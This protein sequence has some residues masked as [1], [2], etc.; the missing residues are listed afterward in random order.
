M[1]K[2]LQI[3][4]DR[5]SWIAEGDG[6]TVLLLHGFGEDGSIWEQQLHCLKNH[7]KVLVPDLRGS[8]HS[9]NC[10]AS[11]SIEQMAQDLALI[12]DAENI[13]NCSILG[14]SMGGYIAL[15]FAERFPDRLQAL[16]LIHSTAFGDSPEKKQVRSK[17]IEF[18]QNNGSAT[19]FKT[20][21]PNLFHPDFQLQHPEVIERLL[22]QSSSF[23]DEVVIG[24]YK[25]MIHRPDR[26][27][28]LRNSK[29]PILIFIG[30][31]DKAVAP[32][33]ALLQASLPAIC[34][35]QLIEG[36][37]HMGMWEATEELNH[38]LLEFLR[39]AIE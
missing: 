12:L 5:F 14:H 20:A 31:A 22:Q 7:Y 10:T 18:I 35:V 13:Q 9:A 37:A 28:V 8:G 38:A 1:R 26:T 29:C 33:D 6:P 32:E 16:G 34:Q 11:E 2:Y 36:V 4:S 27:D 24:Y 3:A 19:F 15:A 23:R 17:A 30:A 25:A 21:I 39:L